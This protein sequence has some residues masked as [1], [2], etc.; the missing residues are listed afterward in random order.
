MVSRCPP[1][2]HQREASVAHGVAGSAGELELGALALEEVGL[3]LALGEHR[4]RWAGLDAV[5]AG[6]VA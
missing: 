6:V 4:G 2:V 3:V 5:A 1:L